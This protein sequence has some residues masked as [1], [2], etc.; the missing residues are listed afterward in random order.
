ML[1][2]QGWLYTRPQWSPPTS[3][4][5]TDIIGAV[6]DL[7]QGPQWSPPTSGGTT[8]IGR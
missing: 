2:G 6:L 4:G 5:T 8:P 7:I 1:L 3:G